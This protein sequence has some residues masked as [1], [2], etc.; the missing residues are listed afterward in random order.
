MVADSVTR[1]EV[2]HEV[3][4][5]VEVAVK[6]VKQVAVV[7][8]VFARSDIAGV[9]A[10]S[11]DVSGEVAGEVVVVAAV[12]ERAETEAGETAEEEWE[13]LLED[14]RWVGLAHMQ[15]HSAAEEGL[16]EDEPWAPDLN[17]SAGSYSV[18]GVSRSCAAAE[19][20]HV[21]AG[22]CRWALEARLRPWAGQCV[23]KSCGAVIVAEGRV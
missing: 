14:C 9:R 21:E 17:S 19:G 13:G 12:G 20:C 18:T 6:A 23:R 11:G 3:V 16:D 8:L 4:V 2:M 22:T 10:A 7:K 1:V 15:I 5:V